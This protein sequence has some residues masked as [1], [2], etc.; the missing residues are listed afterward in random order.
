MG[1]DGRRLLR[2]SKR[3][4][5]IAYALGGVYVPA[6]LLA[7]REAIAG[8]EGAEFG[9]V[10]GLVGAVHES[11]VRCQDTLTELRPGD[12]ELFEPYK[13]LLQPR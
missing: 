8:D 5:G 3:V 13:G 1:G 6:A 7:R 12:D 10:L 2:V 4:N 9:V 11:S